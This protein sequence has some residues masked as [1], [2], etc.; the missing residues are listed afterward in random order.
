MISLQLCIS[1]H[2]LSLCERYSLV[3]VSLIMLMI[4][5]LIE[6]TLY[7][8]YIFQSNSNNDN[9]TRFF[10]LHG[11]QVYIYTCNMYLS[12][13]LFFMVPRWPFPNFPQL[14]RC[15]PAALLRPFYV[16]MLMRMCTRPSVELGE[17]FHGF[18]HLIWFTR[19]L[20]FP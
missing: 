3:V 12:L 5:I 6:T 1:D 18:R 16:T 17:F 15:V 19:N 11:Q 9:D 8:L 14:A 2:R 13:V 7:I 20:H 4:M 10:E